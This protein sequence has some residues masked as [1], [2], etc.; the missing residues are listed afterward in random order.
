MGE[1]KVL[2]VLR[3]MKWRALTPFLLSWDLGLVP[4]SKIIAINVLTSVSVK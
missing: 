2:M 3:V 1:M 4:G